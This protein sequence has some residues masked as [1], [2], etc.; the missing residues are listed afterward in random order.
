MLIG[1]PVCILIITTM[2]LVDQGDTLVTGTD[3]GTFVNSGNGIGKGVV[4][5]LII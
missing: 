4:V 2:V 5:N 3:L 1:Q